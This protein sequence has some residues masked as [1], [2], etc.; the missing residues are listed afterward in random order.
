MPITDLAA[1]APY[2]PWEDL[3]RST[4]KHIVNQTYSRRN[5]LHTSMTAGAMTA[6]T[7]IA[8]AAVATERHLFASTPTVAS[9]PAAKP[10]FAVVD[11]HV[12]LSNTLS[13][14]QAIQLGKDR[15]VQIGIVEHPGPDSPSRL[16]PTSSSTSI[17]CASIPSA[18]VCS[19]SMRA[20]RKPSRKAC[21][22]NWT[23]S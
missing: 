4:E 11:Y 1:R 8:G 22:M 14:E 9:T 20:G 15:Q 5:F 18:S 17:A 10:A 2:A 13:I 16:T 12:H 21:W 23:T 3:E 7:M 19:R 6:G